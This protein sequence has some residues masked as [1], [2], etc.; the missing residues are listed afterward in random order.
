M[1]MPRSLHAGMLS[2]VIALF[3]ILATALA[4][5][6]GCELWR[7][8]D[9]VPTEE[10]TDDP[11]PEEIP[12]DPERVTTYELNAAS[13]VLVTGRTVEL[14][15]GLGLDLSAASM[16]F[17]TNR[18]GD[19]SLHGT[20][21]GNCELYFTVYVDG[22][23]ICDRVMFP[24][25]ESTQVIAKDLSDG[26]HLIE[27]VRQTEG[28]Y[29]VFTAD[30][31]ILKGCTLGEKPAERKLY[32]EF[33]GDS[34]TCGSGVL[35][36]YITRED[37]LTYL[38][39]QTGDC[40][41]DLG[42]GQWREEDVTNS[43]AYLTARALGADCSFISYSAIGLMRSWMNLGFDARDLY[44]R[45]SYLR[46]GGMTYD[47][48]KARKPDLVVINLGTNDIGLMNGGQG[49]YVGKITNAQ[50]KQEVKDFIAQIRNSYNDP[51]LRIV[52]AVGLMGDATY[53]LIKEAV[54]EMNDGNVYTC[55]FA[56]AMNGHRDHPCMMQSVTAAETLTFFLRRNNLHKKPT[57]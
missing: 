42:E 25:G 55:H 38:P 49:G 54:K 53:F 27:I 21:G 15:R 41:Y 9:P 37:M 47:F 51:D 10:N 22:E 16:R 14:D 48:S 11:L 29:G 4:M 3:L 31:L 28:Q 17:Y 40:L 20:V 44:R 56:P 6:S 18:A 12:Y 19:V 1:S 23:R 33:I 43:Y 39:A 5:L 13:P 2:R 32:V 45:G 7:R 34:I 35:C 30:T 24:K 52:W 46:P 26:K 8:N 36:K 50:Y 57:A